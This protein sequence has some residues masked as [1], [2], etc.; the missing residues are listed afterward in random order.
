MKRDHDT[1]VGKLDR[2][3]VERVA[4]SQGLP[5]PLA[6]HVADIV[7]STDLREDRREEVFRELVAH[8]QDGLEAGRSVD[9]LLAAAGDAAIVSLQPGSWVRERLRAAKT[10]VRGGIT[11]VAWTAP[12]E[13]S[14]DPVEQRSPPATAYWLP[15]LAKT[16]FS[17]PDRAAARAAADGLARGGCPAGVVRDV[18]TTMAF[19]S[20][21]LM[22]MI[23]AL[24]AAGWSLAQLRRSRWLGAGLGG[25]RAMIAITA[26]RLGAR[27]P[28][29]APLLRGPLAWPA[30]VLAP[31]VVPFDLETYLQFH[32]SKVGAQTR[33]MIAKTIEEGREVGVDAGPL[34]ALRDAIG[35]LPA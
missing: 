16:N 13:G 34:P 31:H 28:L 33:M 6:R 12:L 18:G 4:R 11:I 30:V 29:I 3:G 22:P 19:A 32:F 8:F 5:D 20:A 7:M 26:K 1:M 35:A 9:E 25:A 15:P 24:E 21:I 27:G 23:A 2:L 14:A 10:L 17:S